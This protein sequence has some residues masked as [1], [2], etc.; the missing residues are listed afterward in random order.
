[1]KLYNLPRSWCSKSNVCT[2]YW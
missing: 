2:C 1:M